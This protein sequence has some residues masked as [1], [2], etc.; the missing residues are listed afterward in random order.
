MFKE[1]EIVFTTN[2]MYVK[3]YVQKIKSIIWNKFESTCEVED[4]SFDSDEIPSIVMY[5]IVSDE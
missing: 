5:F 1:R 2:R 3:P 4:R